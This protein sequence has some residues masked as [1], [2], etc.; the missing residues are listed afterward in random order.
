MTLSSFFSRHPAVTLLTL[1]ML[2]C[3]SVA[4]AGTNI[5]LSA[6]ESIQASAKNPHQIPTN[7]DPKSESLAEE[8][9]LIKHEL[10]E[11]VTEEEESVHS[12][13]MRDFR[14]QS[15]PIVDYTTG[16]SN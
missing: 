13:A 14:G 15:Q 10:S 2:V 3:G 4:I 1:S 16:T 12:V 8:I 11:V 5:Q 9:R 6:D 7:M